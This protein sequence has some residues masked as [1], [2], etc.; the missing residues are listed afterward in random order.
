MGKKGKKIEYHSGFFATINALYWHV[1]AEFEFPFPHEQE[2]GIKPLRLDML[3]IRRMYLTELLDAIGRFFRKLNI[4]EY[5]SPDKSLSIDDI[6]KTQAYACLCKA[7]RMW[8]RFA[9]DELTVTIFCYRHPRATIAALRSLGRDVEQTYPG[10]YQITGPLT[11]PTQ[12]VVIPQLPEGEYVELKILAKGAKREDIVKFMQEAFDSYDHE[13]ALA[14][15]NI[16]MAANEA[17]YQKLEEDATMVGA[18]ERFN[19]RFLA[20]RDAQSE[21][22]G[23]Q[24]GRLEG[25]QEG[26]L[27][28]LHSMM[29]KLIAE[30]WTPERAAEFTGLSH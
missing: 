5:K 23:R 27:E 1:R 28:A 18:F 3:L 2:L 7:L 17:T 15:L 4:L 24:E 12:I 16:S 10:I 8:G 20:R 19:E 25:R 29:E 13:D 11:V 6:F 22:R 14:I 30:G 9:G 26:R 21:E